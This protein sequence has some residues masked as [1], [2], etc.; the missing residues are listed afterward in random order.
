MIYNNEN[1]WIT[2]KKKSTWVNFKTV[3]LRSYRRINRYDSN[4]IIWSELIN[5]FYKDRKASSNNSE[6]KPGNKIQ[7]SDYFWQ[8]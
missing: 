3:I 8:T 1:E 5:I 6:E 7:L 4:S 2:G